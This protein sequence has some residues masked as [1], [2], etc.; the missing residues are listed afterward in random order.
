MTDE[1]L[2]EGTYCGKCMLPL[3]EPSD[4][5]VEQRKP[6]PECD[7]TS[8]SFAKHIG[9]RIEVH[10][11]LRTKAKSPPGTRR[12]LSGERM[13]QE[14]WVGDDFH[15]ASGTWRRLER[16]I[17]RT[18]N[19]YYEH[20]VTTDG[21]VVVHQDCPLTEHRGHGLAKGTGTEERPNIGRVVN[22]GH[23]AQVAQTGQSGRT[24]SFS[25]P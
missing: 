8:R 9:S 10:S 22:A 7:S 1:S 4:L 11:S 18:R 6:C 5:P 3:N 12:G 17:D 21:T 19:W 23:P 25:W 20:I 15:H 16:V 24:H 14:Q 2:P 13:F